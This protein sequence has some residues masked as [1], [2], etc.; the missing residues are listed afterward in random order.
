MFVTYIGAALAGLTGVG[1][2][3]VGTRYLLASQASA[4][5]FGLPDWPRGDAGAWLYLK[6][7]RDIASGLVILV[8]LVLGQFQ[9][10]GWLV[11]AASITPFGDAL[12]VLRNKGSKT[13]GYAMHGGT[14][15]AVVI[16]GLLLLLGN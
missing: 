3:A 7:I 1:I 15:V 10:L 9:V 8:P 11:L 16:T 4:A 6:G 12:V 13:L 2:I 5:T 14:A